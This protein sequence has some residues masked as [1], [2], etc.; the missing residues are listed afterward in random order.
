MKPKTK[1][2][3]LTLCFFVYSFTLNAQPYQSIFGKE[4]TQYNIMDFCQGVK[5]SLARG[6]TVKFYFENDTIIEQQEYK[7]ISYENDNWYYDYSFYSGIREDTIEGKIY[8]YIEPFGEILTCDFNL[9]VG[10]TFFFPQYNYNASLYYHYSGLNVN[11]GFMI[12]D[13]IYSINGQRTITFEG[14]FT[15]HNGIYVNKYHFE[16]LGY[17]S[18]VAFIEGIGPN[19]GPLDWISWI[20]MLLCTYKDDDL[21]YMQREDL[22]CGYNDCGGGVNERMSDKIKIIPNPVSTEFYVHSDDIRLDEVYIY[23]IQ[24]QCISHKKLQDE[25]QK[26]NVI[27]LHTGIYLLKIK[28]TQGNVYSTK[29]IKL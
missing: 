5:G 23:T 2:L 11:N 1:L 24:G 26:I 19:Y 14:P 28:D 4:K 25:L 12:A 22:R 8:V 7:K 29:I 16:S 3:F 13:S 9:S 15:V 18:K 10:D 17:F 20:Q 6:Q 21:V 27:N